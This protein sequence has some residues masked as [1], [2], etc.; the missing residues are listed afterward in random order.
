MKFR[1]L[2]ED[3]DQASMSRDD[4][5]AKTQKTLIDHG[6]VDSGSSGAHKDF[7][8]VV[9][10]S[11]DDGKVPDQGHTQK[12]AAALAKHGWKKT[13]SWR[14]REDQ[15]NYHQF[16]HPNGMKLELSRMNG[17]IDGVHSATYSV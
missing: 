12:I 7:Q 9:N 4:L 16:E 6:Y 8:K 3:H 5:H 15:T 11:V 14:D 10:R 17:A 13:G 1:E 2:F